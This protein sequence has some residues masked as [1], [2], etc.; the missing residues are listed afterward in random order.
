MTSI[1]P[2][3]VQV[4]SSEEILTPLLSDTKFYQIVCDWLNIPCLCINVRKSVLIFRYVCLTDVY[5]QY[6]LSVIIK[7][8]SNNGPT[9][10]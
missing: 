10:V 2:L 1:D 3:R 5:A 9:V 7:K 8:A 6:S 4:S